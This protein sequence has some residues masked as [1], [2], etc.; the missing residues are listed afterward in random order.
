[1]YRPHTLQL[2]RIPGALSSTLRHRQ[3]TLTRRS[4]EGA[5]CGWGWEMGWGAGLQVAATDGAA[6]R[7]N[8]FEMKSLCGG[9]AEGEGGTGREEALVGRALQ[10]L[11][12]APGAG[13]DWRLVR[14]ELQLPGRGETEVGVW[15]W[16]RH[17]GRTSLAR[18]HGL[19]GRCGLAATWG[20]VK[21]LLGWPWGAQL[22]T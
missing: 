6:V 10:G 14:L 9:A 7:V 17:Q 5:G 19:A 20:G 1:M 2:T 16:D 3:R 21:G 8:P 15:L 11:P 12:R 13:W 22:C 18:V 4:D